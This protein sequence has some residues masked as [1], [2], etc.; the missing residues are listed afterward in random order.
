MPAAV[1]KA[2]PQREEQGGAEQ[3]Q[4]GPGRIEEQEAVREWM[5]YCANVD[6]GQISRSNSLNMANIR[7]IRAKNLTRPHVRSQRPPFSD[8][9]LEPVELGNN[10]R[11]RQQNQT[12]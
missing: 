4:G 12:V 10:E 7:L 2:H 5:T 11:G 1:G 8:S 3:N 6:A 9:L